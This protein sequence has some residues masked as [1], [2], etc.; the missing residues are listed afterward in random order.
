ML[1][2]KREANCIQ[3]K[4]D[5]TKKSFLRIVKIHTRSSFTRTHSL[6]LSLPLRFI[7]IRSCIRAL[8][9]IHISSSVFVLGRREMCSYQ[10]NT[11]AS[12]HM[13]RRIRNRSHIC[14]FVFVFFSPCFSF[15]ICY[16]CCWCRCRFLQ[17]ENSK[18]KNHIRRFE[19]IR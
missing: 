2:R 8:L 9:R 1:R 7:P 11:H 17:F 16:C 3:E 10:R 19:V 15:L 5:K 6:S 13:S 12:T 18:L 14:C 4:V